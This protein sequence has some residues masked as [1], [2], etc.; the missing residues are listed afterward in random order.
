M[1][2]TLHT[3][4]WVLISQKSYTPVYGDI[5]VV[6]QPNAYGENI[7]KRIIATEGQIVDINF[8][9]GQV[10]VDGQE[11]NEPYIANATT[12]HYDVEFPVTVP[13][14]HVFVMGDNRQGSIDSR[15]SSIGFIKNDYILG[16]ANWAVTDEGYMK[17]T[18]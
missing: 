9:T 12:N 11:L 6:S 7:V 16:K 1:E 10:Y 13:D 8:S 3:T 17:L 4:D 18:F 2:P 14:D 15:S 5:V